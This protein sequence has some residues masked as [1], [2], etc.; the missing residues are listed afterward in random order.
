MPFRKSK[1]F[2]S[3]FQFQL[4]RGRRVS[5]PRAGRWRLPSTRA[6]SCLSATATQEQSLQDRLR[7]REHP[8]SA[9][10]ILEE[11]QEMLRRLDKFDFVTLVKEAR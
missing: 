6:C 7:G 3:V 1:P 10:V 11:Q 4:E 8:I 2:H 5:R 9:V